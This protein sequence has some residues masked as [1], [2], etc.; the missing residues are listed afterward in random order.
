VKGATFLK[1][2]LLVLVG[3]RV[4][5]FSTASLYIG[6]TL[7]LKGVSFSVE[8]KKAEEKDEATVRL[9]TDMSTV[10]QSIMSLRT[11]LDSRLDEIVSTLK[12]HNSRIENLETLC[13]AVLKDKR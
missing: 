2:Q 4:S 5:Q 11:H 12:S 1:N 10:I 8:E 6:F 3:K 13:S 9:P 7:Q